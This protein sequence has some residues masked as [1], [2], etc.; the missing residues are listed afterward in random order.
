[1]TDAG[2]G[3]P[4]GGDGERGHGA[5]RGVGAR[6]RPHLERTRR[7]E[8]LEN[9]EGL[10]GLFA[11]ETKGYKRPVLVS[12]CAGVASK[13]EFAHELGRHDTIG[14]DLVALAVDD[15][16]V[17]G[18]EPLFFLDSVAAGE[19]E[20]EHVEQ[21]VSGI[22]DGCE[23]AG[24]A[25][26][27]GRTEASPALQP[28][29]G[30]D[31]A[32]FAVGIVDAHR[33]LG[34]GMVE[35]GDAVVAMASNG[36]HA[37]GYDLVRTIVAGR[38]LYD[39]HGL[40]V[41]TLGEALLRPARIYSPDCLALGASVELH[42]L[43]HVTGG[44]IAANLERELPDHL[45]AVIDIRTF[46]VPLLFRLLQEWGELAEEHVWRTFNMGAGM[47]ALVDDGERAVGALRARGVDAWVC[48][49][50][51]NRPGVHLRA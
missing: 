25:L 26:I 10:G 49:T 41:Q 9:V 47:L 15:L 8:V 39:D 17:T 24:C 40:M 51:V 6:V 22:A 7:K 1:M 31:V 23:V 37:A 14:A 45:G 18:A 34:P 28:G 38:D 5:D 42:A 35:E 12:A 21:I 32:G 3:R 50:V 2:G 13:L 19:L 29:G 16:A 11:L 48:G 44:G 4:P 27:G 33:V 30:Y 43:S 20:P 36:L 46:E